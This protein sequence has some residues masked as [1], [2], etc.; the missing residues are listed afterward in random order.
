MIRIFLIVVLL[1]GCAAERQVLREDP[2]PVAIVTGIFIKV[3]TE[4]VI[5][6]D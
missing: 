3:I 4:L 1:S 6:G 5:E 2:I